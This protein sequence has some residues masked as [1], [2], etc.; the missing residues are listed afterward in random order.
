[1]ARSRHVSGQEG[2]CGS[3]NP[4][5]IFGGAQNLGNMIGDLVNSFNS[6]VDV[7]AHNANITLGGPTAG[8]P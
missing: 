4:A 7:L 1:M 8:G 3:F 2:L 6:V 5:V